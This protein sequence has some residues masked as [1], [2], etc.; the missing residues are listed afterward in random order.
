MIQPGLSP[1]GGLIMTERNQVDDQRR[2]RMHLAFKGI[3]TGV[4]GVGHCDFS[5][6]WR[7]GESA[8]SRAGGS[9]LAAKWSSGEFAA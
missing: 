9:L 7:R 2:E 1:T 3:N 6:V 5:G 4:D 8:E